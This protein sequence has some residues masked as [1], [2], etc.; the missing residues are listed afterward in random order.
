MNYR[1]KPLVWESHEGC[2]AVART[3]E[4]EYRISFPVNEGLCY[5]VFHEG[6]RPRRWLAGGPWAELE[7]AK[8]AAEADWQAR[9]K[10]ALEPVPSGWISVK[11]RMP[12]D[13]DDVLITNGEFVCRGYCNNAV[14]FASSD[15]GEFDPEEIT[16]WQPMPEPPKEEQE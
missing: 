9:V 3:I 12:E 14:W 8:A 6:W 1:I 15:G 2:V 7:E 5:R 11:E 10:E 16:H 13:W 4:G